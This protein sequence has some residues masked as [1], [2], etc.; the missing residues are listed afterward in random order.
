[1]TATEVLER[2]QEFILT[3]LQRSGFAAPPTPVSLADPGTDPFV[4]RLGAAT[5]ATI[6]G[7]PQEVFLNELMR[8]VPRGMMQG[9]GGRT[10]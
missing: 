8:L 7:I 10:R 9:L 4:R 2:R 6:R 1:M 3:T 5:T